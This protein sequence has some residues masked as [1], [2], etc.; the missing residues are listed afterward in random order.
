MEITSSPGQHSTAAQQN[1]AQ[2]LPAL[3]HN[4][5]TT[6]GPPQGL[7]QHMWGWFSDQLPVLSKPQPCHALY[8]TQDT[9]FAYNIKQRKKSQKARKKG[10]KKERECGTKPC[11]QVL[12]LSQ[13]VWA[14]TTLTLDDQPHATPSYVVRLGS[15]KGCQTARLLA[16]L[17]CQRSEQR[18]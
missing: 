3:N 14:G 7:S 10:R 9:A 12:G 4:S 15:V 13:A 6:Q 1:T 11:Q 16:V 8:N 2:S 17:P 18:G 5:H